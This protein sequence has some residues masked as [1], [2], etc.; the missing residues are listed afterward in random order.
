MKN[1]SKKLDMPLLITT[2]ILLI[3]GLVMIFSA[4]SISSVL[5]YNVSEYHFFI[6]Q[7]IFIVI[8]LVGGMIILK[9]PLKK[10]KYLY[11]PLMFLIIAMLAGLFVW[12][13]I[14]NNAQ[15]W[16][17]F[18]PISIQP[19]EFAKTVVVLYLA[20]YYAT[21]KYQKK[22]YDF[23][24]PF[25][26]CGISV[27]LILAQPDLGTAAII[28]FTMFFIFLSLPFGKNHTYKVLKIVATCA[29]IVVACI[30]LFGGKFLTKEQASRL[31]FQD[32]CTR[33][34]EK[35]GYQVCNGMIAMN[36]GGLF[37]VGLGNSTQK[38]LYLPESHTDFIFPIIIE[39]LGAIAGVVIILLYIIL[40]YRLLSIAKNAH[41]IAG[42][43][44][45]YGTFLIILMHIFINF[46]GI[47][48]LIPLTGVPVPFLSYGGSFALNLII[49]IFL[50]ERVAIESKDAKLKREL[51]RI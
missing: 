32:P 3:L 40:L 4:S 9:I 45:A 6:K 2:M 14:T 37:G 35:T 17:K 12:G 36:N 30:L 39:E 10:Y 11:K 18:G 24:Y 51:E 1:I 34:T 7:L 50:C 47:L 38:Y 48:A 20:I 42:S 19:S 8:G 44:I 27:V 43:I 28:G 22:E 13:S 15:S 26:T 16:Y 5:Q 33:Y 31:T 23:V 21:H 29:L 49:M 46:L 41:N 25:I